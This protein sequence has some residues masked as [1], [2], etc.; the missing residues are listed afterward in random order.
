MLSTILLSM[1][2]ILLSILS[3]INIWSV[4][5]TWIGFWIWIWSMT[6]CGLGQEVACWFQSW[7]TQLVSF[8]WPKLTGAIDVKMD[9]S[10]LEEKQ[11]FK[12]LGWLFPLNWIGAL[13]KTASKKIGAF[14]CS[15]RFLSP[16]VALYL[17][18]SKICPCM[19]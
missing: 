2:M 12:M 14:V 11:S 13:A 4:A 16:K 19:E 9:D 8:D 6:H 7:K 15:M 3:E 10:V 18:K 5:T 1:L 17:Y